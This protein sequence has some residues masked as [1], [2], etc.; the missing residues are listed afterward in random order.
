LTWT[1]A[2]LA[3][4]TLLHWN[5]YQFS[6]NKLNNANGTALIN[7]IAEVVFQSGANIISLLELKNSAVNNIVA[8]LIP[9]INLANGEGP[10]ALN[11]WRSISIN[12]QKNNEAY[13]VLY[14][15]NSG[16]LPL[17]A[18]GP[19]GA[20]ING[21]TNQSLSPLGVP[22]GQLRF[23]ASLTTSGGRKPY[24]VAFRT[25]DQAPKN[26]SVVAYH[27]MF[28]IYSP[29]GVRNVGMLAQ[30]RAIVDA[31]VTVN[32]H[33]SLTCGDF[34]VDFDPLNPGAYNNLLTSVP[35]SQSTNEKTSLVNFTPPGGY[36]TSP[37]YRKNAYDNIFKYNRAGLP[38]AGG[39]RVVDLINE[40]TRALV[41]NGLMAPE[42]GAFVAGPIL[43]G[44]L[45]QNIPPRD[46]EDAWHIVRH[47]ISDHL[48]VWVR[49]TI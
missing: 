31:G 21:L 46:F 20:Q 33:A 14:K 27:T 32:M 15:L 45:I 48:P 34:N 8:R 29:L 2:T 47:A 28:G 19:G 22:S 42:A 7:Y 16:F 43:D 35:S 30:S 3:A 26:F 9:A 36:P 37:E 44:N 39:G 13:V 25:T 40:S 12:S 10:P 24:Y 18:A 4:I 38:P 17:N 5:I 6:N 23:N 41:G 49:F 1:E 11:Q